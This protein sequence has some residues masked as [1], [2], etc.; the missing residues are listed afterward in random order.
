MEPFI[1]KLGDK[2]IDLA[3]GFPLTIGDMKHMTEKGLTDD[4]GD[5]AVGDV[6]TI[7]TFLHLLLLKEYKDLTEEEVELI[8]INKLPAITEFVVKAFEDEGL[9]RPT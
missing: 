2:E 5:I 1:L 7:S 8:P 6:T 4:K 9:D 3:K